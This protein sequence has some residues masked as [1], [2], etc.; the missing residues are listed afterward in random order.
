[1]HC[2][3]AGACCEQR[4][5]PP[6][7]STDQGDS[8][9]VIDGGIDIAEEY[10]CRITTTHRDCRFAMSSEIEPPDTPWPTL[11]IMRNRCGRAFSETVKK[12]QRAP[13]SG[14]WSEL[15]KGKF[16]AVVLESDGAH[17][18]APRNSSAISATIFGC[19]MWMK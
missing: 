9:K 18:G 8:S 5:V 19:S 1:M 17:A 2:I 13:F 15:V 7:P 16:N 14:C 4:N 11:D 10:L 12:E 3:D 6:E